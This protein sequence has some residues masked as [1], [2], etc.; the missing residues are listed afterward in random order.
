MHVGVVTSSLG[1]R[2]G[3]VCDPTS[4]IG[5]LN[6]HNDDRGELINRAGADEH[7]IAD[8]TKS[9][10]LG[11][12]PSVPANAGQ[13][14]PS[15]AIT[16]QAKLTSD[17]Q[18][19]LSGVHQMGC[20]IESQLESWYRFLVQPDPYGSIDSTT[21]QAKL[22]GVDQTVLQQRHDFLRPDSLV[23]IVDLTDENDSEIDVRR[24]GGQGYLFNRSDFNPP[25]ATSACDAD[26]N[27]PA[28]VSCQVAGSGDPNCSKGPYTAQN[29]WGYNLNLRHVHIKQKYGL[30]I[31]YT[32]DRYARGLTEAT[33]PDRTGEYPVG[34]INYVGTPNC[35]NPL[36]A[37]S[38]PDGSVT[39]PKALC[40]LPHGTRTSD[41]VF[42]AHIGGVP[43]K[44]LHIV[45]GDPNATALG[46]GDWKAI[47][48]NDPAHW[49]YTGIDPHMIESYAPRA[50][51]PAPSSPDTADSES[52]REW[53]T[54]AVVAN[55][56]DLEYACTFPLLAPVDCSNAAN[57]DTCDCPPAAGTP[58]DQLPPLCD[59]NTPTT[60]TRG[61]AYPTIRELQVAK[62]LGSRGIVASI[63]PVHA[64]EQSPGDP[65][66]GYR[67]AVTAIVDR[68]GVA[69]AKSCH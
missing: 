20:G 28:C 25:R 66:F 7:A 15:P 55:G 14:A 45:P 29:D 30:D 16:D 43:N 58:H 39:D 40:Q 67:P 33:V 34:A 46:D 56:V 53:I 2:G 10:F 3:D 17:V 19:L 13:P 9:N 41:L 61:K 52:G 54:N 27:D 18:D 4:T 5:N 37:E 22:V 64:T 49:D 42:Y 1:P 57:A 32:I 35:T 38:L 62:A 24:L 11:W 60:Q 50:G 63:C 65:L 21:G 6:K 23:L 26:P 68:V 31:Q 47:L 12:F 8:M 69:L 48:G 44:L 36:F 59:A 51:M